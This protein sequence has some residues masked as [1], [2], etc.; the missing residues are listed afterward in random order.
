MKIPELLAPAGDMERLQFALQYGADAV[1]LAGKQFGMRAAVENFDEAEL[2]EAVK[3][4][5]AKNVKVY[6]TCNA[7][8]RNADLKE[9]PPFLELAEDAEID[10]LII[11]DVGV[12]TMAGRHAP[13]LQRHISTQAGILNTESARAW[14]DMGASRVILARE[15]SLSE[16]AV[17]CAK[18][19]AG[20]ET[21][22]FVHGAMCVSFSGRCLIS[23][24][25]IGRDANQGN[26]AQPCR[27]KYHL[28]EE[29]RP[30]EYMEI[31]EDTNGTHI[32]NARDLSMIAH[33]KELAATGVDSLKIEGRAKSF[34]YAAVVTN[35]YR[36]A[37]DCLAADRPV[38]PLWIAEVE[39]V[40]HRHYSTGF[41][42]DNSG[43]GQHVGDASY[44]R[45]ATVIGVV[46]SCDA[47]GFATISQRNRFSLGDTLEVLTPDTLPVS[48]TL[49]AMQDERGHAIEVA[50]HPMRLVRMRLPNAVPPGT[51]LRR[52]D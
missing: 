42:F 51:I 47:D 43:G 10:A 26:C 15:M 18:K 32:M 19:P 5:H 36:K 16:I 1:Y 30:G 44:I 6:L 24:Y 27:W 13:K 38:D 45:G 41:Y 2:R 34:Y 22:V 31:T 14:H 4:A 12:F 8:P 3:L 48:F 35:A 49:V 29:S 7:I 25:L 40:S 37:L 9:L 17:L 39:K 21:E 50:P 33:L 28:V 52:N 11:A 46:E 20:L 23:Q